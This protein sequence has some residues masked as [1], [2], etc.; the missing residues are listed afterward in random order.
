MVARDTHSIK[1]V[2]SLKLKLFY[3]TKGDS[4]R[5]MIEVEFTGN[6]LVNTLRYEPKLVVLILL[7]VYK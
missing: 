4:D 7:L 6:I 1:I 2:W 5:K 3:A